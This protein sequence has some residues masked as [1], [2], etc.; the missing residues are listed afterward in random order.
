MNRIMTII[1]LSGL[2]VGFAQSP[3]HACSC[4]PPDA[5]EL[6]ASS[7]FAFVGSIV[8][9]QSAGPNQVG[10]EA[11]YTFFVRGWA[12]GD[13]GETVVVRSAD[14]GAA[15]GFELPPG[16]EAA[17]FVNKIDGELHGGLCSTM[18]APSLEAVAPL[19]T[20]APDAAPPPGDTPP[21][22]ES[23]LPAPIGTIVLVAAGA[24]AVAGAAT[25][26][27]RRR[28]SDQQAE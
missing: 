7:D 19:E 22:T 5:E 15:C 26:V 3:A 21:T 17:I 14:N 16:Q 25:V 2:L 28:R 27:I 12:K 8:Q 24:V 23:S 11:L 18:D 4:I 20:P 10:G 6:L 1:L 13:L 9:T